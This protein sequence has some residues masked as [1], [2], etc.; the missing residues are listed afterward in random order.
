MD[1]MANSVVPSSFS[2][3]KWLVFKVLTPLHHIWGINSELSGTAVWFHA[4][5]HWFFWG[6]ATDFWLMICEDCS[7]QIA[8]K[9]SL[10][11]HCCVC[12]GYQKWK[13]H[14]LTTREL[15]WQPEDGRVEGQ[16]GIN[17]DEDL[18]QWRCHWTTEVTSPEVSLPS[19]AP[20]MR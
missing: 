18:H 2:L 15:N 17:E 4:L 11:H 12:L 7:V 1:M 13:S 16:R 6:W 9:V 3:G 19:T 14:L 20:F 10:L 5:H 8:E